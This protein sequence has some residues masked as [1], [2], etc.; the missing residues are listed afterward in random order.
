MLDHSMDLDPVD[1]GSCPTWQLL[2][3]S[4]LHVTAPFSCAV[5]DRVFLS[6]KL[7]STLH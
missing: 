3:P 2:A 7:A 1:L 5:Q 4:Y 6:E